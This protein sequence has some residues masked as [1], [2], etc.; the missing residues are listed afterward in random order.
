MR[1]AYLDCFSGIS[2]NMLL[3]AL[4]DAGFS[5]RELL[6]LP[7]ILGLS[8]ANIRIERV[9]RSGLGAVLVEVQ[10]GPSP[11]HR[12]LADIEVILN[13]SE[14][15]PPVKERAVAI[16][17]RL[18]RAEAEVHACSPDEVHFHEVGASDALLDITGSVLGFHRLGV[19]RVICS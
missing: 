9:N 11:T 19:E 18:A 2:G 14:L 8:E 5:E 7:S 15:E 17:R 13:R 3:G 1:L 10:V 6:D 4:V 16:F 12:H